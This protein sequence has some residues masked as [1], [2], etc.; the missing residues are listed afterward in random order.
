[1]TT[2]TNCPACSAALELPEE[3]SLGDRAECPNCGGRFGLS[4]VIPRPLHRVVVVEPAETEPATE[5]SVSLPE[6]P[7]SLPSINEPA[8]LESAPTLSEL[9]EEVDPYGTVP[10]DTDLGK[11]VRDELSKQQDTPTEPESPASWEPSEFDEPSAGEESPA[12]Q[13]APELEAA[14][15]AFE[16]IPQLDGEPT[17]SEFRI[18]ALHET[19][20]ATN[21]DT[22]Q[23]NLAP[24]RRRGKSP[25]KLLVGTVAGGAVGIV[26]GLFAL[27][28]ILGPEGDYLKVAQY[29]P[30]AALPPS[31]HSPSEQGAREIAH[32]A[33]PETDSLAESDNDSGANQSAADPDA[34]APLRRDSEVV[35]ASA[36]TQ[37][38]SFKRLQAPQL[39]EREL[40]KH[41]LAFLEQQDI[42]DAARP[43]LVEGTLDDPATVPVK[44]GAYIALC[45]FA[46][47]CG[48]VN[49]NDLDTRMVTRSIVAKDFFRDLLDLPELRGE[50]A[51]IASRWWTLPE[52]PNRGIVFTGTVESVRAVGRGTLM[53]VRMP[54]DQGPLILPAY[55][56]GEGRPIGAEI[57]VV[58]EV[59]D[60]DDSALNSL[61]GEFDK[62]VFAHFTFRV[63]N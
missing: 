53:M 42:A 57:G 20:P 18:P 43:E 63:A 44:G 52:P 24:E 32:S 11:H 10:G 30:E 6:Q 14:A 61:A 33:V 4:E 49:R 37:P 58:G 25:L 41:A 38:G 39:P 59:L 7:T 40:M 17:S 21:T 23:L 62:L 48:F 29:L 35:A 8:S 50:V 31:F 26:G 2:T 3:Y 5:L 56:K 22:L 15:S 16:E 27:L 46:E 54:T 1:M 36:E 45:S 19:Q 9:I 13:A 60:G 55:A 47:Q 34:A 28:W 51:R 12:E